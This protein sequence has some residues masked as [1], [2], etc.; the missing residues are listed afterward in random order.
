MEARFNYAKAAPDA[1]NAVWGVH[2]Y[3]KE[4]S[5][6]D[7]NLVHL[8]KLRAS[9]MNGCVHCVDLHTKEARRDGLSEQWIAL[10]CVWKEAAIYTPQERALLGWTESLINLSSTGAP[11][12]DYEALRAEFSEEECTKLTLAIGLINTWNMLSA[13]FRAQPA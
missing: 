1:V 11:D 2:K 6:L 10:L 7:D 4:Q 13:G 9:Q 3:I 8:V 5:G 12:E